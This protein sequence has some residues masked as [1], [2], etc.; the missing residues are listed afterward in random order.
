MD[1]WYYN[2]KGLQVSAI[3]NNTSVNQNIDAKL[4]GVEGEFFWAPQEDL[5]FNLSFG[6]THSSIGNSQLVD[7][8]NPTNG[9]NDVVLVKDATLGPNVGQNCVIYM[10]NG[11]TIT[12]ADNPAFTA[13]FGG[14]FFDPPGGS[15]AIA[16]AGV[17]HVNYG[18]CAAI[19]EAALNPFGYSRIDPTGHGNASG[20]LDN[21]SG[22]QLQN[23]PDFTISVGAQYTFHWGDYTIVPRA[24]YYWQTSMFGRIFNDPSDKI[25][26]W[27]VGNAQVTLNAPDEL[28]YVSGWVKNIADS[29]NI[30]GAYLTS[31]TSGLYTNAFLGDPRTYG[32]TAG[33]HF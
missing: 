30:T 22:N 24:D 13:A 26:A 3:E 11:Q 14:L 19:P 33:I 18:S 28:W 21:L 16:G 10:I 6:T 1:V 32:V 31:S 29:N 20:A 8:R 23:T 4:W 5:Q 15:S 27:G 17:P 25:K 2:Y 12:P 7:D 9:R